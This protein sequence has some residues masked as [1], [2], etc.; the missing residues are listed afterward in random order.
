MISKIDNRAYYSNIYT[1]EVEKNFPNFLTSFPKLTIANRR[2]SVTQFL[3]DL[4]Q[5]QGCR[6]IWKIGW[7]AGGG[8][9]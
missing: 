6:K 4:M 7:G 8:G 3:Q 2:R 1:V 9:I 5:L